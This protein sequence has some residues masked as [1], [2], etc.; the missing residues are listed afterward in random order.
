[1]IENKR[2]KE[3]KLSVDL[4]FDE[5]IDCVAAQMGASREEVIEDMQRF[6]EKLARAKRIDRFTNYR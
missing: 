3:N 1:M 6:K 2:Y 5:L 4:T